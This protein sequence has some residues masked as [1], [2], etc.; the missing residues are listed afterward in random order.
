MTATVSINQKV[1]LPSYNIENPFKQREYLAKCLCQILADAYTLHLRT[2]TC[3]W[4][5]SK[6]IYPNL[7]RIS[8]LQSRRLNKV[9]D[10]VAK[11]IHKL[12]YKVPGSYRE[13]MSLSS[14]PELEINNKSS[15][16]K[17][18]EKLI[19]ANKTL[20]HNAHLVQLR[21]EHF[22]E[23]STVDLLVQHREVYEQNRWM[24]HS[25]LET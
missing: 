25:I 7:S 15:I 12:G 17:I 1:N 3:C 20:S 10:S 11:T 14:I 19:E 22:N 6:N 8:E 16:E 24:L 4:N 9:V 5:I 2:K 18:I 23:H 13:L 21:A